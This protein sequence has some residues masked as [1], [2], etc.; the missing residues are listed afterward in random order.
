[1]VPEYNLYIDQGTT[2]STEVTITNDDGVPVDLS[3][4]TFA[5]Q[6]RKSFTSTVPYPFTVTFASDGTDGRVLLGMSATQTGSM[7]AGRYVYDAEYNLSG[8]VVRF[9][10]GLVTIFPSATQNQ[11]V[12]TTNGT[13]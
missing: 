13:A 9:L 11:P 10:K 2:F 6:A 5:A 3:L 8:I 4:A 12:I 7:A 1:M